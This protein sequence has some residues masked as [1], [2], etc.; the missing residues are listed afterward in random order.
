MEHGII[1]LNWFLMGLALVFIYAAASE[2][3]RRPVEIGRALVSMSL[4]A[5]SGVIFVIAYLSFLGVI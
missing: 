4:I 2:T 1:I 3:E 5:F